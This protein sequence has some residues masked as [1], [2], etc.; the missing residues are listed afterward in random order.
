MDAG[1]L[2]DVVRVDG[3][4]ICI[5][6][7]EISGDLVYRKPKVASSTR[8]LRKSCGVKLRGADVPALRYFTDRGQCCGS[9]CFHL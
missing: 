8:T 2:A 3:F 9:H 5:W 7:S 6:F 4:C 1:K